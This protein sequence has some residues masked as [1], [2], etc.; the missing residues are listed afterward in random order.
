LWPSFQTAV[1]AAKSIALAE[2]VIVCAHDSLFHIKARGHTA[3][4]GRLVIDEAFV[5]Q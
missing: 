4:V 5:W 2:R 3:T 1:T